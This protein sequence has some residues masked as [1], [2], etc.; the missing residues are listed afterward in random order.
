M[1]HEYYK[2]SKVDT[3]L[4]W[5][6]DRLQEPSTCAGLSALGLAGNMALTGNIQGA[7]FSILTALVAIIKKEKK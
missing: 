3:M 2:Q 5:V 4:T 1:Y 6:F 7:I